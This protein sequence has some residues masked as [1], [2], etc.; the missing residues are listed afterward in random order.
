MIFTKEEIRKKFKQKRGEMDKSEASEK[1]LAA[2]KA[3][4]SAEFYKSAKQLMLYMPL[5]NETDTTLIIKEAFR[6]EKLVLVPST[7]GK[8]GEITP[9][10]ITQNT[11]FAKG[12]F[13]VKEPIQKEKADMSKTDV[14]L[15]PGIA[16][17]KTG[18]RIG[19]GKGCYDILLK[20]CSAIKVGFCY[21]YQ[22]CNELP[23][24]KHD[25]RMDYL[26]TEKGIFKCR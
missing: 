20:D 23:A 12:A 14:V 9:C 24:E 3:F 17:D 19:F 15:V 13:S 18:A 4:L 1:S 16:F 5:G 6:D 11:E 10:F 25:I 7:D 21:S 26:V 2:A 22:I 8:S